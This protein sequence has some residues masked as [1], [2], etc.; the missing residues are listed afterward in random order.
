ML[1]RTIPIEAGVFHTQLSTNVNFSWPNAVESNFSKLQG[2][3]EDENN[4]RWIFYKYIY[5]LLTKF[6]ST[7]MNFIY[8]YGCTLNVNRESV[9]VLSTGT[10]CY[11]ISRPVC[12]FHQKVLLHI[13]ALV[14]FRHPVVCYS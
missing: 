13:W 7:S 6:V 10:V 8:P 14:Q 9:S 1:N 11:P 5:S 4:F 2:D 12:A 3:N